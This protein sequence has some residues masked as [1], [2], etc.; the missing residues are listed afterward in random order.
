M[1]FPEGPMESGGRSSYDEDVSADATD[2]DG[3]FGPLR[4]FSK[5]WSRRYIEMRVDALESRWD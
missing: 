4:R 5:R 1:S 3:L 2:T